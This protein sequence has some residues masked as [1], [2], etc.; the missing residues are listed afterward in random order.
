MN[1]KQ[2]YEEIADDF[3]QTRQYIWGGIKSFLDNCPS[4]SKILEIGCGNGKNMLYRKDLNFKGIDICEKFIEICQNKN[5]DV[6]LGNTLNLNFK[7][8]TFDFTFSVAVIHHL[9]NKNDRIKA[10]QE[11]IRVTKPKGHIFIQVWAMKQPDKSKRKF[12]SNDEM[13]PWIKRSDGKTV[14]RYYHIY[15]DYELADDIKNIYNVKIIK[16]FYEFGNWIIILEKI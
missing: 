16:Y 11:H 12:N 13:V 6:S 5:L 10:I 4:N 2:V 1:I 8:N 9:D 3:D 14:Y 7:D 15:D